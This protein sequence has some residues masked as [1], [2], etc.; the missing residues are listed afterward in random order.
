MIIRGSNRVGLTSTKDTTRY[1]VNIGHY[2]AHILDLRHYR[3][4]PAPKQ[5]IEMWHAEAPVRSEFLS[6][7]RISEFFGFQRQTF[8]RNS[9]CFAESLVDVAIM[10]LFVA[11]VVIT[12]FFVVNVA[13]TRSLGCNFTQKF[14]TKIAKI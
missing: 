6:L 9:E 2:S 1:L 13:I 4:K 7:L 8:G 14:G 5:S 10:R 11:N 12:R 3:R